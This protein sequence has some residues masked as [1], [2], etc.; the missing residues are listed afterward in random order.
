M[1]KKG[2][3]ASNP[4]LA[5]IDTADAEEEQ[6]G[7]PTPTGGKIPARYRI[8]PRLV[9]IKSR[10]VQLLVAPTLYEDAKKQC[11][12]LGISFNEF[13]NRALQEATYNQYVR[14][15]IEKDISGIR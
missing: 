6:N 7:T 3:K 10:R 15:Q 9:E 2:F 5:F 13:L 4:A 14:E 11:D 8:D 12:E 1:A